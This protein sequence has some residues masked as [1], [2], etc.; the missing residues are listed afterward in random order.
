[1]PDNGPSI[2]KQTNKYGLHPTDDLPVFK[3]PKKAIKSVQAARARFGSYAHLPTNRCS[4]S[5]GYVK[6][7]TA[8]S[9]IKQGVRRYKL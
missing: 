3:D 4:K 8:E 6:L 2:N 1:M 7:W 9:Q 5:R